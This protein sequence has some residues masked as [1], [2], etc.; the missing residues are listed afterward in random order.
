MFRSLRQLQNSLGGTNSPNLSYGSVS[1][2]GRMR[3]ADTQLESDFSRVSSLVYD[4]V[5]TIVVDVN[6]HVCSHSKK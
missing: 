5:F 6:P 4:N 2:H 1:E 3:A